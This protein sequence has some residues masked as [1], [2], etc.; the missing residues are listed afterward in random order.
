MPNDSSLPPHNPIESGLKYSAEARM[1]EIELS[2][3]RHNQ[4]WLINAAA[5]AGYIA[6]EKD[7]KH[8][9]AFLVA[10]YGLVMS[11]CWYLVCHGSKWWQEAWEARAEEYEP[12]I[13]KGF[14]SD[15]LPKRPSKLFGLPTTRF[16]VTGLATAVAAFSFFM[17]IGSCLVFLLRDVDWSP[18]FRITFDFRYVSLFTFSVIFCIFVY[19]KTKK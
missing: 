5:L 14:F 1:F 12:Y 16:S 4:F 17:W 9:L 3:K 7:E 10:C 13:K 6:L 11:F 19:F 18:A 15:H 8:S 2:W